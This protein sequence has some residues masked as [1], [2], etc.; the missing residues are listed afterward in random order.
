MAVPDCY[1][2]AGAVAYVGVVFGRSAMIRLEGFGARLPPFDSFERIFEA[3]STLVALAVKPES[4]LMIQHTLAC[5][6]S[7]HL[8]YF[9]ACW[10]TPC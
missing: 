4:I 7:A 6:S 3:R 10:F 1:T 9:L 5:P 2:R 8:S